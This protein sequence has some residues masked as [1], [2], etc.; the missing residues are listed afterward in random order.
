[1]ILEGPHSRIKYFLD[2][3]H[4][5]KHTCNGR[6]K[7]MSQN[8]KNQASFFAPQ[9]FA[10]RILLR[11][12]KITRDIMSKGLEKFIVEKLVISKNA[13][14]ILPAKL[15]I[16]NKAPFILAMGFNY[17]GRVFYIVLKVLRIETIFQTHNFSKMLNF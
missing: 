1:M 15:T 11:R 9:F 8:L 7:L 12:I 4:L 10:G 14:H 17:I 16:L 5:K 3:L 6:S 13:L 2:S